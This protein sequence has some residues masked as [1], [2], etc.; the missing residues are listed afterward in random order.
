MRAGGM[1]MMRRKGRRWGLVIC[2]QG[3]SGCRCA[4]LCLKGRKR[5]IMKSK[6][7]GCVSKEAA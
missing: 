7:V 1:T 5:G 4:D 2:G 3:S 6:S